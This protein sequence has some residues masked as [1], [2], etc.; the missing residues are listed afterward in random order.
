MKLRKYAEAGIPHY[1]CVEEE[2]S[3]PVV[4]V[5]GLDRPT[6]AYAPAAIVRGSLER[7]VPFEVEID[8]DGLVPR[9]SR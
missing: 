8:L 3:A 5:Y 4:H 6:G 7:T 9:K 2:S 1:W